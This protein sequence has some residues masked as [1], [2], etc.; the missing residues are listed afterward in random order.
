MAIENAGFTPEEAATTAS[1]RERI[2][3]YP[4]TFIVAEAQGAVLGYI[5]GPAYA[6]R[7]LSDDLFGAAQP[8]ADAKSAPYQTV[9]SLAVAPSA[10]HRGLGGLLLA[11][12]RDV[13]QAQQRQAIT[14][15]CLQRLVP[16]YAA[17]EYQNEG[18]SAS[19]HAGEQ[20][21]NMVLPL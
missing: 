4:D 17:N 9:L 7:Y 21:Y 14:L 3:Q 6:K 5:V 8:N 19:T 16:F 18:L 1:M 10:Q 11:A 13:A 15:T 12:L 20:W 2:T